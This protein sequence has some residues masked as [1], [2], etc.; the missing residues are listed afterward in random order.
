[1]DLPQFVQHYWLALIAL[2]IAG[3]FLFFSRRA[4]SVAS[5][6]GPSIA[7]A[8]VSEKTTTISFAP[9][10]PEFAAIVRALDAGNKIEAIKLLRKSKALDLTSAKQLIDVLDADRGALCR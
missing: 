6:T 8:T 3:R 4:P 2:V 9:N 5:S 1:M 7:R 10:D